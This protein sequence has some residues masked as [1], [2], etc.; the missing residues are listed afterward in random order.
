MI[1]TVI[2]QPS[3]E[4]MLAHLWNQAQDR[5]AVAK[6]ADAIDAMLR[7][8]PS[9][10]GE[11]RSEEFRVLFVPPLAVHFQVSEMDRIV[12]VLKIWQIP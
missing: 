11:S 2:W 3:A 8:D 5:A 7:I 12:K 9:S 10:L 1:F 6:A 4:S